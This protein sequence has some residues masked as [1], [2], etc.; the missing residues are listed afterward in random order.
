MFDI[1]YQS[2]RGG[3]RSQLAANLRRLRVAHRFSLSELARMT[4]ISK[5]TLSGIER[6]S[7][8]PTI[9]TLAAVA[10]AL[11]V[12]MSELLASPQS[13]EVR[14]VRAQS[15][16]PAP[17]SGIRSLALETLELDGEL[18]FLRLSLEA[19]HVHE[20]AALA[21]GS[22]KHLLLLAGTL[23]AGPVERISEL[24]SGDYCSFPADVAH[25]FET[26]RL[27]AHAL[28]LSYTPG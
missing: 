25:V 18:E 5:A 9:D 10:D 24:A 23:I 3:A 19:G 17:G 2:G 28:V 8:N 20:L 4:A 22:R 6:A 13:G 1:E 7:A 16:A 21:P 12:P 14:I 26:T 15:L 11:R 27:P